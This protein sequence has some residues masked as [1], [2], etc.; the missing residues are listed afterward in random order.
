MAVRR[1]QRANL[2]MEVV[3][4]FFVQ[5]L[6]VPKG[7]T[8]SFKHKHTGNIITMAS[9]AKAQKGWR[10]RIWWE[11]KERFAAPTAEAV[12]VNVVFLFNRPKGHFGKKGVRP[13]APQY[14]A[15]RPDCTKLIRSTE[16]ALTGIAWDDDSQIVTQL[17]TKRYSQKAGAQITVT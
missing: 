4:R 5:G 16:D 13:S 2:P 10:E 15:V 1:V 12:G 14:P 11:A 3:M 7:S 6:P 17:G 8:H 9:N